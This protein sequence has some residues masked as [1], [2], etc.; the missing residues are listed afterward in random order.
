MSLD[1]GAAMDAIGQALLEVEG[2]RVYPYNAESVA[3]P[4][5]VVSLPSVRFDETKARG[6]DRA[7][8]P[9]HVLISR[10]SD[11]TARDRLADYVE[12]VGAKSIKA[13]LNGTLGGVVHHAEVVSADART[14][15]VGGVDYSAYTFSVEVWQ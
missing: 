4:A 12:G 9:V 11:R 3:V 6:V 8:Y 5:A 10:V 7:T 14:I 13:A 1:M 2:L 15:Q